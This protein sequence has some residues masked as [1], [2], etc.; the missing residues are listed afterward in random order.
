[1]LKDVLA[2]LKEWP[3]WKRIESCPEQIDALTQRIEELERRLERCPGEGCPS[4]GELA[5]RAVGTEPM[6]HFGA[7]GSFYRIM[8]CEKCGYRERKSAK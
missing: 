5:F 2:V 1:M 4:C 6:E 3:K 8:R 7:L